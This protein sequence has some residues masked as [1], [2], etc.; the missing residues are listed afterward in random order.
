MWCVRLWLYSY[1]P[2]APGWFHLN[3][4]GRAFR[5]QF[6]LWPV[7]FLSLCLSLCPPCKE[8][9]MMTIP[10]CLRRWCSNYSVGDCE[11]LC[12]SGPATTSGGQVAWLM[13]DC[14]V[15]NLFYTTKSVSTNF[16]FF[17]SFHTGKNT[18]ECV[19]IMYYVCKKKKELMFTLTHFCVF[20]IELHELPRSCCCL[21]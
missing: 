12:T 21:L 16:Y 5:Q 9:C 3:S 4:L 19:F 15:I 17:S 2:L 10:V 8:M 6:Q 14:F 18:N 7:T 1:R 20:Y 13:R 11:T